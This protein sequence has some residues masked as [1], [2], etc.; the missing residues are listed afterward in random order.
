MKAV[1]NRRG[2]GFWV[3]C[4]QF[5]HHVGAAA[6]DSFDQA[7]LTKL[8]HC[9]AHGQVR[10]AV[11]LRLIAL[12]RQAP[13]ETQLAGAYARFDVVGEAYVDV[14]AAVLLWIEWRNGH[15]STLWPP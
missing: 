6:D 11:L 14:L 3:L 5:V 4:G 13:P 12:R 9:A 10:N 15:G 2:P 1:S 8:L 7:A